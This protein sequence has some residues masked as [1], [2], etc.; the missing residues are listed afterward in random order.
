MPTLLIMGGCSY[1]GLDGGDKLYHFETAILQAQIQLEASFEMI[2]RSTTD[3][4]ILLMDRALLDIA[5]YLPDAQW[6]DI[7]GR[8]GWT[9]DQFAARYD[10]ILHL[11]TAAE[12]AE[13]FYTTANNAARTETAAEAIAL[14]HKVRTCWSTHAN[15]VLVPNT[16][17]FDEKLAAATAEV[18]ALVGA[19][20]GAGASA[21]TV[22]ANTPSSR[23]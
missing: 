22:A 16:G 13:Q 14:D 6:K 10:L 18:E 8:N 15:H 3:P 5:A 17:G 21:D 9:E 1:P 11:V 4:S 2:A 20:A 7:I 12:G 23:P 19:V